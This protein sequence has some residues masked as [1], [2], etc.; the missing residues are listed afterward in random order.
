MENKDI[1]NYPSD[2]IGMTLY[3][4]TNEQQPWPYVVGK[5]PEKALPYKGLAYMAGV[6]DLGSNASLPNFN[7]E[8][9][10]KLTEGGDGVD[11]NPAD[12][13]L[14][15]LNKIGMGDVKISGI[16]NYRRYCAA[17]DLLISTPMDESKSKTAREIVNEIATITNA[18]MFWSNDQLKSF[19]WLTGL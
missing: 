12:Y 11:V 7:F 9:K 15:I 13:I 18:F 17:A 1:Y 3:Y 5:H 8:V 4:G 19:R 2:E 10:G 16:E 14:Y 6:I